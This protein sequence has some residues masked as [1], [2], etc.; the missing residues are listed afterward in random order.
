[1]EAA[2][3]TEG[4]FT[5]LRIVKGLGYGLDDNAL[6]ALRNRRFA[7]A[8]RNGSRVT[9]ISQID[10]AFKLPELNKNQLLQKMLSDEIAMKLRHVA[11]VKEDLAKL[12]EQMLAKKSNRSKREA[13]AP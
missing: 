1:M 8:Y 9:V 12:H 2:F 5:V 7:P 4:N 13:D 3:D 11:R 6:A 10:V